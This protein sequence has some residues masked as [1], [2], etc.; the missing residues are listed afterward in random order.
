[1]L[2]AWGELALAE[3]DYQ[4]ALRIAGQLLA[5]PPG[6]GSGQ[7]IPWLLKLQGEALAA[8]SYLD[9]AAQALE[10]AKDGALQRQERPLLWQV[11]R[12][13]GRVYHRMKDEGR[14]ERAFAAARSVIAE[15]AASINEPAPRE[16]F[17]QE[18]LKSLPREKPVPDAVPPRNGLAG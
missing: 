4:G 3:G 5:S 1:M 11:H 6:S 17:Y 14:A 15:L 10:V 12:S 8:M 16:L 9:E 2:W 18:A 13:L 7:P